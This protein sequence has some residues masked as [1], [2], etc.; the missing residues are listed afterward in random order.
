[1]RDAVPVLGYLADLSEKIGRK[2]STVP[3]CGDL[4]LT[5]CAQIANWI[6]HHIPGASK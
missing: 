3:Y 6:Y 4:S 5:D 2:H 1:M